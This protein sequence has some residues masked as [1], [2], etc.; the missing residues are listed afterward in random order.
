MEDY[1]KIASLVVDKL[2]AENRPERDEEFM[3]KLAAMLIEH[4]APCHDLTHKEVESVKEVIKKYKKLEK[5]LFWVFIMIAGL[6]IKSIYAWANTN[7]HWGQ[8]G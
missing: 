7:I 6:A 4:R 5:G 3:E 8:G 2:R 1:E